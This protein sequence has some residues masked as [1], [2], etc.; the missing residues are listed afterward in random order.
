MSMCKML[1][2]LLTVQQYVNEEGFKSSVYISFIIL[3]WIVILTFRAEVVFLSPLLSISLR[4]HCPC[5][6]QFPD[7][8][9]Q[10]TAEFQS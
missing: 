7:A 3:K 9:F 1:S 8:V 4:R 5:L 6:S 2:F 10:S